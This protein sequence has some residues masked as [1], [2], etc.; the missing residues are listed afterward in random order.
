MCVCVCV[1]VYITLQQKVEVDS[2]LLCNRLNSS[3]IDVFMDIWLIILS[4]LFLFFPWL[5]I[6][7]RKFYWSQFRC[8]YFRSELFLTNAQGIHTRF[9]GH[10]KGCFDKIRGTNFNWDQFFFKLFYTDSC[11]K[12]G[13]KRKLILL[14]LCSTQ[15]TRETRFTTN[16]ALELITVRLSL[17]DLINFYYN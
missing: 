13:C 15:R 14:V 7:N 2:R 3:I 12:F 8:C 11:L 6:F 16:L 17:L 4:F 10:Y 5:A 9:K 1:C